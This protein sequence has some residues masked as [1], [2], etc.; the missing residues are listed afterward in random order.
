VN[1][2]SIMVPTTASADAKA[3][4]DAMLTRVRFSPAREAGLPVC[5]L[6]RMQVNFSTR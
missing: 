6:Q 2:A 3:A 1:P 4:I 5:E